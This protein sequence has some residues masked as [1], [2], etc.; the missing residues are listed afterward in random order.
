MKRRKCTLD[1]KRGHNYLWSLDS[2]GYYQGCILHSR[3]YTCNFVVGQLPQVAM[4][5]VEGTRI[6]SLSSS[7][8]SSLLLL[9]FRAEVGYSLSSLNVEEACVII[10]VPFRAELGYSRVIMGHTWKVYNWLPHIQH[11]KKICHLQHPLCLDIPDL[12]FVTTIGHSI[13]NIF[14]N[15]EF[16]M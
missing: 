13:S 3:H 15:Y 6:L 8:S 14:Q 4:K 11:W 10:N 1:C 9:T 12:F 16:G 7:S 5:R 2:K